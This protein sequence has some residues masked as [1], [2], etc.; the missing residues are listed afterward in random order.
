MV[1]GGKDAFAAR[2]ALIRSAERTLDVQ[3]YIWHADLSGSLLMDELVVAAERG[4]AIRLL[5]DDNGIA[6]L[7]ARLRVLSD[8]PNIAM[9]LYNPFT[10]RWPKVL[11]WLF[12][13]RRL[14]HRMHAKSLTADGRTT[15]VGGR[16][17]GDEYFAAKADGLFDDLDVLAA[18]PAVAEVVAAFEQHWQSAKAR[19]A[20]DVLAPV[21]ERARQ[22]LTRSAAKL[23]DGA[24]A[25]R[26]R[27]T[28]RALPLVDEMREGR[29]DLVWAP[30]DVTA[31]C[32]P[33]RHSGDAEIGLAELLPKGLGTPERELVLISG[34][35]V[36]TSA[37]CRDLA[38]LARGGTTVRVL[39][40]SFAATDVGV[41]H[42]GYAHR[43]RMLLESGVELFEMPAPD[44]KPKSARKF[45]RPGSR[46]ARQESGR[47]LHAKTYILDR[48]R[49]YVGS[50]NLDPRSVRLNTELGLV[51][52]DMDLSEAMSRAFDETAKNSYRLS[53]GDDGRL[54]WT[55]E[56]DDDPQPEY[57]EP[58]TTIITSR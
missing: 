42:A 26:Y 34:Y 44:D 12:A 20:E 52:H 58:H 5:L 3:Y 35:F 11:N 28:I 21:S 49:V 15:I 1:R 18:G 2:V 19:C 24:S 57:V 50:A 36:P 40:N 37:G 27:A 9:K 7:D 53:L 13:F 25:E 47:S 17:V 41:V 45:M 10:L 14:N 23:A 48:N 32:P 55:D 6:G 56:R 46:S 16:N 30:V 51:I 38:Q 43:R 31:H 39:T 4:V 22:R 33:A 8:H 29:L 54:C